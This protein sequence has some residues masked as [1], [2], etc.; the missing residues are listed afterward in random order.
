MAII[1]SLWYTD[2]IDT[3]VQPGLSTLPL[4]PDVFLVPPV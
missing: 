4:L 2:N 3:N 1:D